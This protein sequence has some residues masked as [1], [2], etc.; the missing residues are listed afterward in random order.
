MPYLY[1]KEDFVFSASMY[2][3]NLT[4]VKASSVLAFSHDHVQFSVIYVSPYVILLSLLSYMH[5]CR[6]NYNHYVNYCWVFFKDHVEI[7]IMVCD[8]KSAIT[9]FPEKIIR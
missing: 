7:C 2:Q 4:L 5:A 8:I 3:S 9:V 1:I 6:Q